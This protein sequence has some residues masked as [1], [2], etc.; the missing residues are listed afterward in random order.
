MRVATS[1]SKGRFGSSRHAERPAAAES[2]HPPDDADQEADGREPVAP[3]PELSDPDDLE[4]D[5]P[6]G[7]DDAYWDVFIPDEDECDPLPEPGDF[8]VEDRQESGVKDY[9]AEG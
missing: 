6:L 3:D 5:D 1:P 7:G 4:I 9:E 8:W 2:P